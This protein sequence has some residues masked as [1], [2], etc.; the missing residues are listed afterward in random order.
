MEREYNLY[1]T[2]KE[3]GYFTGVP[4][5]EREAKFAREFP[6]STYEGYDRYNT[7]FVL[8]FASEVA[9]DNAWDSFWDKREDPAS[10]IL[11]AFTSTEELRK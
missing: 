3:L 7:A 11:M 8:T 2:T 6:D 5:N 9:R 4:E 10:I 1:V